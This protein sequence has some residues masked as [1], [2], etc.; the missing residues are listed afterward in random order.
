MALGVNGINT[1]LFTAP[2]GTVSGEELT[3][4]AGEIFSATKTL[5]QPSFSLNSRGFGA[6]V[7]VSLYGTNASNNINAIKLAAANNAGLNVSLSN[8][9]LSAINSLNAKAASDVV[10]NIAQFKNGLI[11]VNNEKPDFSSQDNAFISPVRPE[12]FESMNLGKDRHGSGPFYMPQRT[13][14]KPEK[15]QGLNLLA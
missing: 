10:N 6:A 2:T 9:A 12:I 11:H 4:V 5:S 3:K 7:D 14:R 1:N 13:G 15:E 8:T